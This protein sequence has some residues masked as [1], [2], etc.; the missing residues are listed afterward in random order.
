MAALNRVHKAPNLSVETTMDT[1]AG[2]WLQW[3]VGQGRGYS[4]V[5]LV[6]KVTKN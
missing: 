6:G 2:P 5:E 1:L 3:G 4:G